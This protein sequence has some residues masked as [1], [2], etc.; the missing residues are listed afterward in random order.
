M[1]F[2]VNVDAVL[3]EGRVR[4]PQELDDAPGPLLHGTGGEVPKR[5]PIADGE[6][7]RLAENL[8]DTAIARHIPGP[9]AARAVR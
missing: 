9:A 7:L 3:R 6:G 2:A 5:G 8:R 1:L 4:V